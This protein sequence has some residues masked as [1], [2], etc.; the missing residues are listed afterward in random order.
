MDRPLIKVHSSV[1]FGHS[2]WKDF[3]VM[4]NVNIYLILGSMTLTFDIITFK[5][6]W[7]VEV[8]KV[9]ST[10]KFRVCRWKDLPVMVK[11]NVCYFE[12]R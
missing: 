8:I 6:V 11:V 12:G 4:L 1:K 10:V 3:S 7:L 2:S 9:H 5:W